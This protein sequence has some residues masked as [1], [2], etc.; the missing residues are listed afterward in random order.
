M[1][2]DRSEKEEKATSIWIKRPTTRMVYFMLSSLP[3]HHSHPPQRQPHQPQPLPL[4][5]LYTSHEGQGVQVERSESGTIDPGPE[6]HKT[7]R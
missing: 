3:S 4:H 5:W 2:N 1:G 6:G 7:R